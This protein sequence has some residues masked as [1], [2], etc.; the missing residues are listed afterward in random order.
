MY[1]TEK[2]P[3]GFETMKK[4]IECNGGQVMLLKT[5][6][7]LVRMD[8]VQ[9]LVVIGTPTEKTLCRGFDKIAT[10]QG[11]EAKFYTTD[12]LLDMAMRQVLEWP[13]KF[14]IDIGKD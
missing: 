9:H 4:V 6:K 5:P 1:L 10:G 14:M 11:W 2:V 12:W 7:K 13:E 8:E 3:G